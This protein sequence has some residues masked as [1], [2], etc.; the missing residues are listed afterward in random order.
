M[1]Y[2]LVTLPKGKSASILNHKDE[3]GKF[4]L[5]T[6]VVPDMFSEPTGLWFWT[7][8]RLMKEARYTNMLDIT[9]GPESIVVMMSPQCSCVWAGPASGA[10]PAFIKNILEPM[11]PLD[12]VLKRCTSAGSMFGD[13]IIQETIEKSA[14]FTKFKA[15][16]SGKF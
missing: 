5:V 10:L 12:I 6:T 2:E 16:F 3:E 4:N 13:R 9:R 14:K 1:V 11:L 8:I 15:V 7:P